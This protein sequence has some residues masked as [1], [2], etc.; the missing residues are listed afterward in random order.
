MKDIQECR[1]ELDAIDRQ[2]VALF[3]Q[4]MRVSRNVAAYKHAHNIDIL[5][6][7]REQEVLNSRAA[8]TKNEALKPAVNELFTEIMRLSRQEQSRYL[9]ALTPPAHV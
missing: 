6:A 4:R 8:L 9:D 7:A 2:L 1:A 5:D 3:E